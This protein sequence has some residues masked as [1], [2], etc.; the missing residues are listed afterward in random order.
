MEAVCKV[1]DSEWEVYFDMAMTMLE[2][3]LKH[4]GGVDLCLGGL[5]NNGRVA[6]AEA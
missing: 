6:L 2:V 1:V 5:G 3:I 4:N